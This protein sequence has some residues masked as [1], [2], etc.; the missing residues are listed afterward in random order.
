MPSNLVEAAACGDTGTLT[1]LLREGAKPDPTDPRQAYA[2]YTALHHAVARG[3]RQ[4]I[5]LLLDAGA[6]ADAADRHGN[7]PLHLLTLG[8]HVVGDDQIAEML[9]R[10]GADVL[11]TNQA[12]R[13]PLDELQARPRLSAATENLASYLS[14]TSRQLQL[15]AR[16]R[17]YLTREEAPASA[18]AALKLGGP[19]AGATFAVPSRDGSADPDAEQHIRETLGS[20][21]DAWSRGDAGAHLAHYAAGFTPGDGRDRTDWMASRRERIREGQVTSVD[22]GNLAVNVDGR[23]AS[24]RFTQTV[25]AG[26]AREVTRKTMTL[27]LDSGHWQITGETE[28][29][30]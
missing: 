4:A 25:R 23:T 17:G 27:S 12:G 13:T 10:S 14:M 11:R 15:L 3:D 26:G 30:R 19:D 24:A 9:V 22:I 6:H 16:T 21:A 28:K 18:F 2:G 5:Q 20:W 7:G 1:R 8:E 29:T